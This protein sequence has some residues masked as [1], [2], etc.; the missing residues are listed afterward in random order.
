[1]EDAC[2]HYAFTFSLLILHLVK[3]ILGILFSHV[4]SL[5]F[6]LSHQ[7]PYHTKQQGA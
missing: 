3:N 7:V 6:C 1:M 4:L 5:G 2:Y